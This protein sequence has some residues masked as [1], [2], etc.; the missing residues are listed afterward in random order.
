ME[1]TRRRRRGRRL[2]TNTTQ[3]KEGV[4]VHVTYMI[5]VISPSVSPSSN[6]ENRTVSP[7]S[8]PAEEKEDFTNDVLTSARKQLVSGTPTTPLSLSGQKRTVHK[9]KSVRRQR[10]VLE[11]SDSEVENQPPLA[12]LDLDPSSDSDLH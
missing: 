11:S 6:H 8:L 7:P 10:P 3:V 4:V 2:S 9:S 1:R 5:C 12:R